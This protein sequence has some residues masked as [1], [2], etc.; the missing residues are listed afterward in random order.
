MGINKVFQEKLKEHHKGS[1]KSMKSF[2]LDPLE[3]IPLE[4][5]TISIPSWYV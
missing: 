5:Q 2:Y 3:I 1:S 4:I